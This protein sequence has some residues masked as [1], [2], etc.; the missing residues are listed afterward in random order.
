MFVPT[1][2][3]SPQ[4]KPANGFQDFLLGDWTFTA[5]H[6]FESGFRS[7]CCEGIDVA[8]DG[9][10][11]S[12]QHAQLVPGADGDAKLVEQGGHDPAVFQHR[13]LCGAVQGPRRH[14]RE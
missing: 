14:I 10:S 6:I 4:W 1:W 12:K 9:S 3:W 11:G 2:L 13:R 8:L 7:R 5:I